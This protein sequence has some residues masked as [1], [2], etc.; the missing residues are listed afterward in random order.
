MVPSNPLELKESST[1]ETR[2]LYEAGRVCDIVLPC[3]CKIFRSVSELMPS[4]RVYTNLLFVMESL[5][6]ATSALMDGGIEPARLL[7]SIMRD[8]S[9]ESFANVVGNEPVKPKPDGT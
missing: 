6:N 7:L 8:L 5:V 2:L 1:R 9:D 4:G 3:S